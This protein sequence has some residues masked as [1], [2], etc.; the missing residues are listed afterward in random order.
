MKDGTEEKGCWDWEVSESPLRDNE[1]AA[2]NKA[3]E[4]ERQTV[5]EVRDRKVR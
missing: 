1:P 2:M 3:V 5:Q 4:L